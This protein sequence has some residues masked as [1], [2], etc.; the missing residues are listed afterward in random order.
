[1]GQELQKKARRSGPSS[2][3]RRVAQSLA[4]LV[5]LPALATLLPALPGLLSLLLAGLLVLLAALLPAL[6][7]LLVLLAALVLVCHLE[8]SLVFLR[9]LTTMA[10]SQCSGRFL[11]RHLLILLPNGRGKG[12]CLFA[13]AGRDDAL[14]ILF[15][16]V[17][18]GDRSKSK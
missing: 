8:C 9:H 4:V 13:F 14:G 18:V 15:C 1:M 2:C 6:A 11:L 10:N 16:R 5:L 3:P 17:S 7:P 12:L